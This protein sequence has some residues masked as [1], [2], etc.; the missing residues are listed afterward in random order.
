MTKQNNKNILWKIIAILF[1][2]LAIVFFVKGEYDKKQ[3]VEEYENNQ[4]YEDYSDCEI[5]KNVCTYV[6]NETLKGWRECIFTV[7]YSLNMTYEE[8]EYELEIGKNPFYL[9]NPGGFN[10]ES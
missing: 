1:F 2:V 5:K 4:I 9:N 8:I 10:N 6:L 7:G 3:I